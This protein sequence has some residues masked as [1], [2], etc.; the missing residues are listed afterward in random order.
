MAARTWKTTLDGRP[1]EIEAEL[2]PAHE[3]LLIRVDGFPTL[4]QPLPDDLH[5][6]FRV[7]FNLDGH[8]ADLFL[9]PAGKGLH[10]E[11]AVDGVSLDSGRPV[12]ELGGATGTSRQLPGAHLAAEFWRYYGHVPRWPKV[13]ATAAITAATMSMWA[14]AG[15]WQTGSLNEGSRILLLLAATALSSG[16]GW[17]AADWSRVRKQFAYGDLRPGVVVST[18]PVRVAVAADLATGP[19]PFPFVRVCDQP[20]H[21]RAGGPLSVGDRVLTLCAYDPSENGRHWHDVHPVVAE[22]AS[23]DDAAIQH[24]LERFTDDDWARLQAWYRR[25]QTPIDPGLYAVPEPD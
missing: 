7:Q 17:W 13:C 8:P 5:P 22:C 16:I 19:K 10:L 4:R 24:L 15:V 1:L 20:M 25:V 2:H 12:E 11:L 18:S 23:A 14:A 6:F 21:H 3:E 9:V